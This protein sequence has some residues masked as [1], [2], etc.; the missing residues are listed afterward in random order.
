MVNLNS[1]DQ[2]IQKKTRDHFEKKY[3]GFCRNKL[4]RQK[5]F[6]IA[7]IELGHEFVRDKEDLIKLLGWDSNIKK[8]LSKLLNFYFRFR[9]L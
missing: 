9:V 7:K 2:K 1:L 8:L 3:P 4:N 6:E 5:R